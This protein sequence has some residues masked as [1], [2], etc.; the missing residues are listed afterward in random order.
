M[1]RVREKYRCA[2]NF[3]WYPFEH[4]VCNLDLVSK[5]PTNKV[6]FEFVNYNEVERGVSGRDDQDEDDQSW[7]NLEEWAFREPIRV[8]KIF[9]KPDGNY[10]ML[11]EKLIFQRVFAH[12]IMQT[13][14]P[15]LLLSVVSSSSLFVHHELL[16]ARMGV[17]ATTFLSMISLF[18]GSRYLS[19]KVSQQILD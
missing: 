4:V 18:K 6:K 12:E 14:V 13:F 16:P 17:A 19:Y 1:R 10:S 8:S 15:S 9:Y 2:M 3:F 5:M 7:S 11:R